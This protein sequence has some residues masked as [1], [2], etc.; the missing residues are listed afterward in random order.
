MP[1]IWDG[2]RIQG[3]CIWMRS[4]ERVIGLGW[5]A[6]LSQ[7][8]KVNHYHT[9]QKFVQPLMQEDHM[10][11]MI[12]TDPDYWYG[13][14]QPSCAAIL[15]FQLEVAEAKEDQSIIQPTAE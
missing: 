9:V 14:Y 12:I 5:R 15:L 6:H 10:E 3:L 8:S 1:Y 4:C 7:Q 13:I 2:K 11:K